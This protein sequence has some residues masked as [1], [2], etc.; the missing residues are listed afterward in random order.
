MFLNQELLQS[1]EE[2][3]DQI[4]NVNQ[5]EDLSYAVESLRSLLER[6]VDGYTQMSEEKLGYAVQS[7]LQEIWRRISKQEKNE[8]E[9]LVALYNE[10]LAITEDASGYEADEVDDD[11]SEDEEA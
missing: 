11:Y 7:R 8:N 3:F 4:E 1:C 6:D 2:L 9:D 10:A 5:D